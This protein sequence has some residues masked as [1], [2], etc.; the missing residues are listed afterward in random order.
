M[1]HNT[2]AELEL[3][4][5]VEDMREDIRKKVNST[6]YEIGGLFHKFKMEQTIK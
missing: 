3:D 6:A 1:A 4:K 2:D 5:L